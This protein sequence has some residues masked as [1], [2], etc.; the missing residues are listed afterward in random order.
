[1]SSAKEALDGDC[2]K[3]PFFIKQEQE[4]E[5]RTWKGLRVWLNNN[6][7][8]PMMAMSVLIVLA[9]NTTLDESLSSI[10]IF[11]VTNCVWYMMNCF[12]FVSSFLKLQSEN[13]NTVGKWPLALWILFQNM[14]RTNKSDIFLK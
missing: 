2:Q 10:L 7:V 12:Q 11:A 8:M 14:V 6:M 9:H 4:T 5:H 13:E 3:L 1:M